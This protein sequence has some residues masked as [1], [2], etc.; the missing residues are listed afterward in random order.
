MKQKCLI[1]LLTLWLVVACSP[2]GEEG[3]FLEDLFSV[4]SSVSD[5]GESD[6]TAPAEETDTDFSD[7]DNNSQP[8]N[9]PR[10]K[11]FD[12]SDPPAEGGSAPITKSLR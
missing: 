10:G 9:S 3:G 8:A 7:Q 5:D 2:L 11:E 12:G 1:L 6:Q 4:S